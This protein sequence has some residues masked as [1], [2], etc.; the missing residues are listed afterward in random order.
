MY[1]KGRYSQASLVY[2]ALQTEG[3][4]KSL[5]SVHLSLVELISST[6]FLGLVE[7]TLN[8]GTLF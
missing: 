3:P 5:P 8:E 6:F 4:M 7:G 2:W 1:S